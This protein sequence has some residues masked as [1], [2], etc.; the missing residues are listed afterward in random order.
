MAADPS[1]NA[2]LLVLGPAMSMAAISLAAAS[3]GPSA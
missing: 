2:Y 3:L 1:R